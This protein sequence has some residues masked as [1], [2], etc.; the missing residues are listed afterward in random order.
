MLAHS[1]ESVFVIDKRDGS[2][3]VA[4]DHYGDPSAGLITP[5]ERWFVSVGEGVQ[6]FSSNGRL[7]TFFRRGYPP[8][9]SVASTVPAWFMSAVELD[10]EHRLRVLV[11]PASEE[12][13]TWTIDLEA[14]TVVRLP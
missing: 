2:K 4:G 8:L 10:P 12:A 7:L 3:R 11:D 9:D 13:S 1:Y 6:C 5:D 14:E